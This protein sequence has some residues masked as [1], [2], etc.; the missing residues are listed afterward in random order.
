MG[1]S[2]SITYNVDRMLG[3]ESLG[4]FIVLCGT[5]GSGLFY[6]SSAVFRRS[7]DQADVSEK[8]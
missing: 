4:V 5:F 7:F 8:A 3:V 2:V 6:I 1:F